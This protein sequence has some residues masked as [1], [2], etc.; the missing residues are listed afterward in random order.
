[1]S[2]RFLDLNFQK[3]NN[4]FFF[5]AAND[6]DAWHRIKSRRPVQW[7]SGSSGGAQAP[8]PPGPL[9]GPPLPLDVMETAIYFNLVAFSALTW[10]I[11]D[12]GGNQV[13][14]AYTSIMIIFILLLGVIIF[15]VLCYTRL[16]KCSFVKKSF[17]WT[18]SK[19]LEKSLR[20]SH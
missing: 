17:E 12:F 2:V 20:N 9:L 4:R 6:V 7:W 5:E 3:L 15:H 1:M 14:L 19:L 11:L 16:Y 13:A 18:S 8:P 10:Y